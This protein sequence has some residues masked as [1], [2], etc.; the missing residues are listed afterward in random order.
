MLMTHIPGDFLTWLKPSEK[1]HP[2]MAFS[3]DLS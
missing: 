2:S 1:E 3:A